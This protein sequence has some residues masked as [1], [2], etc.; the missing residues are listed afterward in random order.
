MKKKGEI[1][2]IAWQNGLSY[3]DT[4]GLYNCFWRF[5]KDKIEGFDFRGGLSIEDIRGMKT[6]FNLPSLGK[7][8]VR[9]YKYKK[10]KENGYKNSKESQTS[11]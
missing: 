10:V 3:R 2:R 9:Y 1:A 4:V 8:A 11:G 7:L 6:D 5:I